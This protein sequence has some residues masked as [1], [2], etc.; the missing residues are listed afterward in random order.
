MAR[1]IAPAMAPAMRTAMRIRWQNDGP[2]PYPYP[3]KGSVVIHVRT[4]C[5]AGGRHE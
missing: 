5:S 3:Y 4:V 2:Y 1:R